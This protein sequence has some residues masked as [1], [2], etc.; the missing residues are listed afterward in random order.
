MW[1]PVFLLL[2]PLVH[3]L[4]WGLLSAVCVDAGCLHIY[5]QELGTRKTTILVFSFAI[6]DV[7][8]VAG[9]GMDWCSLKDLPGNWMHMQMWEKLSDYEAVYSISTPTHCCNVSFS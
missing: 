3:V 1:V 8:S 7:T 6:K 5:W 9:S 2:S 4:S